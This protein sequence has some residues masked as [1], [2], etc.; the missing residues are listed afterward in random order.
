MKSAFIR[1]GELFKWLTEAGFSYYNIRTMVEQKII[2]PL[3]VPG[4]EKGR[5]LFSRAQVERDVIGAM[6]EAAK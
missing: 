2:V 4:R 3:Y 6:E 5:A 1:R